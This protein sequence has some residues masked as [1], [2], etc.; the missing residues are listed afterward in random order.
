MDPCHN[1]RCLVNAV[2]AREFCTRLEA[3]LAA[4]RNKQECR[5]MVKGVL[6]SLTLQECIKDAVLY[7][8]AAKRQVR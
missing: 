8:P 7:L 2:N 1:E 3:D 5:G 4:G 6:R